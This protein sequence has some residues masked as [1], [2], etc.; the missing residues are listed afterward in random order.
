MN[1][2]SKRVKRKADQALSPGSNVENESKKRRKVKNESVKRRKVK[3]ESV[4]RRNNKTESKKRS[5]IENECA[6][7]QNDEEVVDDEEVP[8]YDVIRQRNIET[9]ERLFNEL[10]IGEAVS[11]LR[12]SMS[13]PKPLRVKPK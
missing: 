13:T 10:K 7:R 12:T 5:N 1:L 4:K 8:M 6:K 2:I 9:R 11:D 3:N